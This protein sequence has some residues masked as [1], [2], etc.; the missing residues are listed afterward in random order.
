[1]SVP[2]RLKLLDPMLRQLLHSASE[3]G[4]RRAALTVSN[5]AVDRAE[6]ADPRLGAALERLQGGWYGDSPERNALQALVEE[7]DEAAWDVQD[8][9]EAGTADQAAYVKA[10][11]KA[12][13]ARAVWYALDPDPLA[14]AAEATYE[15]SAAI[16]DPE[17]VRTAVQGSLI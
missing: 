10:F 2:A 1:M 11:V 4:R 12:R 7:L 6:I 16:E 8:R 5:L 13:T 3:E 14:A 15:A 9:V 17:E